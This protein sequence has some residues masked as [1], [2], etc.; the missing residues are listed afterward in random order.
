LQGKYQ[1]KYVESLLRKYIQVRITLTLILT[2]VAACVMAPS[3]S[4]TFTF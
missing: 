1:P 2:V 3:N 4:I